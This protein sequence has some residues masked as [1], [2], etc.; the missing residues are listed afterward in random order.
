[1][2]PVECWVQVP[3]ASATVIK[4][5][6]GWARIQPDRGGVARPQRQMMWASGTTAPSAAWPRKLLE[7]GASARPNGVGPLLKI[8]A[9]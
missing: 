2:G 3:P 6:P 4:E 9:P 7:G 1:M 8:A 5:V